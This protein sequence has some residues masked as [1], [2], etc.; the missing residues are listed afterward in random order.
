MKTIE[1]IEKEDIKNLNFNKRE[2]L[3]TN[4]EIK[5]RWNELFRAQA[6]GNLL[7]S[8]VNITFETADERIFMV[9]STIWAVGQEFITLK[10]GVHIPVNA[11][12]EVD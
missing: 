1:K 4:V 9:Y 10:G 7:Q 11:V 6:L 8:K 2:V 5:K 3:S 12:L